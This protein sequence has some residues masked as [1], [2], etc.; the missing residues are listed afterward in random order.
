MKQIRNLSL[1][2]RRIL[3]CM[4]GLALIAACG[5][6]PQTV[7]LEKIPGVPERYWFLYEPN[8]P[9]TDVEVGRARDGLPFSE[10]SL[11]QIGGPFLESYTVKLRRDGTALFEGGLNARKKGR[12]RGE[13]SADE[14]GRLCYLLEKVDAAKLSTDIRDRN[15]HGSDG[16]ATVLRASTS[17][18]K[19]QLWEENNCGAIEL[20]AI[21]MT[22]QTIAADI[23]WTPETDSKE[24]EK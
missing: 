20:W 14:Y 12:H 6:P 19:I 23:D 17:D 22:I 18:K 24:N 7:P 5:D 9:I 15:T 11:E 1:R 16:W 13:V 21:Q 3:G 10:I 4:L 8:W 2:L